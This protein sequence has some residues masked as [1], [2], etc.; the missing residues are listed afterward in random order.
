MTDWL[1]VIG[2]GAD[3]L[4]GLTPAARTLL[5]TAELVVGG[6][7]HLKLVEPATAERGVETRTWDSPLERTVDALADE[8]GRRVVVLASGDPMHFGIGVTLARAFPGQLTVIPST[9]AFSLACA[10]LGWPVAEVGSVTLH[11]R[12]LDGLRLHVHPGARLIVFSEDGA[13]PAAVAKLV[14]YLGYGRTPMAVLERMGS[15]HERRI[16]ALAQDWTEACDPLNVIALHCVASP[17]AQILSR[18]PGLPDDAFVHD[19]QLTKSEVRAATLAALAPQP[20]QRL[21]DFGAGCGSI[22]IEWMRAADRAH[23]IAIEEN[24]SRRDMAARNAAALG[25]PK[26]EILAGDG[27]DVLAGL[28]AP[29]AVFIG[30]GITTSGLVAACWEALRQHGR[31]VANVVTLEGEQA[32]TAAMTRYGGELVR[33]SVSRLEPLGGHQGWRPQRP[34][35]QWRAIKL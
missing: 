32:L 35:T 24:E 3:G 19:G 16:E 18:S 15:E 20:D 29:D 31:M 7:R 9:G 27:S 13:T 33:L 1:S 17:Q 21:W 28:P 22:S 25:V 26:L 14:T 23:A 2:I 6:E 12:P 5:D 30:G 8:R 11:G 10:R 34:V 4:T